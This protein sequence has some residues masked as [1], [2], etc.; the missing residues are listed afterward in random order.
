[1]KYY[2]GI[3][4]GGT[5]IKGGIA[6]ENGNVVVKKSVPTQAEK[7]ASG[8]IE[9]IAELCR[10]LT[11]SAQMDFS[12]ISAIGAA[13][14]GMI[15]A[16]AG[17]VT[18]SNNLNWKDVHLAEELQTKTG[19]PVIMSNDANVAALGEANFGAAKG[20]LDS[21][22][23]TLGTGVGSGIII[24]G[25]IFGGNKGAGAE[26]GHTVIH[27]GGEPCT[28][29]L[30]GCFEAYASATALIRSTRRAME[31]NKNSLLW[32]EVDGDI[33]KIGGKQVFDLKDKDETAKKVVET[34][35]DDLAL[36]LINIANV[37]RPQ[38]ILLGGGVCAQ[39]KNLTDPLTERLNAGI[40]G[41][42]L[43]PKVEIKIASLGNDAGF[44]GAVA[45]AKQI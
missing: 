15:D 27:A 6:D 9:N 36:G 25:K 32:Q 16:Q 40:Y 2:I 29:G 8:V 13:I 41:R 33:E 39:G 34:Y 11:A 4:L 18:Y 19:L 24:G 17:V 37:F 7:G 28:C 12:Q 35:L 43:G 26:I 22:T 5:N 42:D 44:L 23:V 30:R 3:D 31:E 14:P 20:V 21:V 10:N 45:L 1:M 38:V